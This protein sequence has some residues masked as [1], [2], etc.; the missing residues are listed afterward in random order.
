MILLALPALVLLIA[1]ANVANLLLAWSEGRR[2]ENAIRAALGAGGRRLLRQLLAESLVL[3]SFGTAAGLLLAAWLL[4]VFPALVPPGMIMLTLDARFDG[5][6]LGFSTVLLA[7][8]TILVV[9]A[10]ALRGAR[11]DLVADLKTQAGHQRSAAQR[12]RTQHLIMAAQ[13]AIGVMVV[14]AGTLMVRS[15]W[16]SVNLRPGFDTA[17]QVATFY[18]VPGLKGYSPETTHRF[19]EESRRRLEALSSV[20]RASYGIRLP[21]QGNEAGWAADVVIPGRE[22]PPGKDAFHIRYTMVGPNYFEVM[23]TRI[24]RGRGIQEADRPGRAPVVIINET[25]AERFWPGANPIGEMILTGLT[26]NKPLVPRE[27]VGIAEDIKIS[28]LYEDPEMYVYVPY[29]QDPQGFGLL[30]VEVKGEAESIFGAATAEIAR[31]DPGLPILDTGS[32]HGH[33]P[34]AQ[35]LVSRERWWRRDFSKAVSMVWIPTTRSRSC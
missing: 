26:G 4:E 31:V 33:M 8:S 30:L 32:L 23:G 9:L 18:L 22:P 5:R 11:P 16:H 21:A 15:L 10:P 7:A 28:D 29:A 19:F 20:R 17:K 25:M 2:R 35:V 14:V 13:M 3:T 6:M 24:L 27:I 1:C 34:W 12:F